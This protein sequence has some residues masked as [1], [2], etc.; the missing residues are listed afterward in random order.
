MTSDGYD[1][2]IK[3]V[4][5]RHIIKYGGYEHI[6]KSVRKEPIVKPER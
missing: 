2:I 1:H 3:S 6:R 4:R 5:Q